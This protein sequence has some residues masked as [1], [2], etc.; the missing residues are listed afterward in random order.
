M[1]MRSNNDY[2]NQSTLAV[3]RKSIESTL[4][5][6][7]KYRERMKGRTY[8]NSQHQVLSDFCHYSDER[9]SMVISSLIKEEMNQFEF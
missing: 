3:L 4:R 9:Q 5:M 8:Y 7:I 1:D 2:T 6:R